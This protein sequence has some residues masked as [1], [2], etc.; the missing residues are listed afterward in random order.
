MV[1]LNQSPFKTKAAK[2]LEYFQKLLGTV[3]EIVLLIICTAA[4]CLCLLYMAKYLWFIYTASPVGEEYAVLFAES[5]R[6]TNDILGGN[7][8]SL[9][10]NMTLTSFVIC[11]IIGA[12]CKFFLITR[13]LYSARNYLG[14]II[15]FGL[16]L[17]YII[18]HY[19][20]WTGGFSHL[21]TA[22]TVAFVPALCVVEGCFSFADEFVPDLV[23]I[24]DRFSKKADKSR[25]K[26]DTKQTVHD[27]AERWKDYR[28]NIIIM[29][30]IIFAAGI[31]IAI[32][33]EEGFNKIK[34]QA[35]AV[36]PEFQAP[37]AGPEA[38]GHSAA[39]SAAEEEWYR[40]ALLLIDSKN[41]NDFGNSIEYLNQ[42]II[43][44]PDYVDA[45]RLRGELYMRLER[46]ALAINDYDEIIRLKPKDG[47]AY[48]MRGEAYISSGDK[49][50]G[51]RSL[52]RGCDLGYC[53]EY[54]HAK[55]EG[56]CP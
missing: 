13:Y 27:F 44:N 30:V 2:I 12:I 26:K 51:C 15:F 1:D 9:A 22:V 28:K 37:V 11:L 21:D 40:K 43:L 25:L 20:Q 8:I 31:L 4:A 24:K 17:T 41:R 32:L 45:Y 38:P 19:I 56:D 47:P 35:P 55:N 16:P 34:K 33:Q 39:V 23:D 6:L 42:A 54:K 52:R 18:A 29:L 36:S 46:Y 10:I 7:I 50:T 48:N 49:E 53:K 14:K 3:V 5:Y